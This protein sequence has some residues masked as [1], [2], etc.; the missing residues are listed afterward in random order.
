MK[1]SYVGP[2]AYHLRAAHYAC[3]ARAALQFVATRAARGQAAAP[4]AAALKD[5][6]AALAAALLRCACPHCCACAHCADS[7]DLLRRAAAEVG[8]AIAHGAPRARARAVRRAA[9]WIDAAL[10]PPPVAGA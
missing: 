1:K 9:R 6:R 10:L 8:V 5:A 3:A 7:A 4:S 2:A